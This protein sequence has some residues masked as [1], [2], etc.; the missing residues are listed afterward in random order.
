MLFLATLPLL[1]IGHGIARAAATDPVQARMT[2]YAVVPGPAPKTAAA[3]NNLSAGQVFRDSS[4]VTLSGTCSNDALLKIYK[5]SILAGVAFCDN[6]SFSLQIDLFNGSNNVVIRSFNA[7]NIEGPA[8]VPLQVRRVLP[9]F[10]ATKTINS[11]KNP[12]IITSSVS[13]QGVKEGESVSLPLTIKGGS[14]PYAISIGWG[15]GKTDLISRRKPGT[16]TVAHT[17][18]H[19]GPAYHSSYNIT[20][21]G[22]DEKGNKTFLQMPTIVSGD[23]AGIA[24]AVRAGYNW[25]QTIRYAWQAIG[26]TTLGIAIFWVGAHRHLFTFRRFVGKV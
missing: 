5:N 10:E 3:I 2:T 21:T 19:A 17:Y 1:T 24:G 23:N 22:S 18:D 11:V 8:P 9:E 25:S 15:D 26:T 6:G 4:P 7:N 13:Y 14:A 16:F 12:F 20:V